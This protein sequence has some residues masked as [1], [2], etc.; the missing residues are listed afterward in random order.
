MLWAWEDALALLNPWFMGKQ[1][2][3]ANALGRGWG[4]SQ[5]KMSLKSQAGDF[6]L[7]HEGNEKAQKNSDQGRGMD[8]FAFLEGHSGWV[9]AEDA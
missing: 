1:C 5:I 6:G 9:E 7:D 3:Q 2:T 4:W 8:S